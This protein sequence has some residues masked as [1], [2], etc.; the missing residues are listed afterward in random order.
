MVQYKLYYFNFR[1]RAE[2]I[3]QV[4]AAAGQE[5]EDVRFEREQ[6]PEF[7]AKSPTGQCPFL[8]VIDGDNT[9]ILTQ[10]VSIARFIARKFNLAGKGEQE[11][12]EVDMYADQV[13]DLLN[14][15]VKAYKET[16]EAR[17]KE[18][19]EKVKTEIMPNNLKM[20]EA[21]LAKTGSGLLAASGLT[22]ADMYL[23]NVL[24]WLGD[25]KEAV[26]A[27]FPLVKQLCQLVITN[28]GIAAWLAKRP[29][30]DM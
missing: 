23:A 22:F 27:H 15:M 20:F 28:P 30:T 1:G 14:E 16:D 6:W 8:E 24:E 17:K 9:F 7:K 29:V 11:Q 2:L 3:R 26:L 25:K 21:R 12:A 10:S 4:F 13:T 5:Y 19:E 18:M